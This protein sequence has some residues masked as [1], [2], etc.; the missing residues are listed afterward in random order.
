M[1]FT[2]AGCWILIALWLF[3]LV[4]FAVRRRGGGQK[5]SV[6]AP[7]ARWG[8]VLQGVAFPIVWAPASFQPLPALTRVILSVVLAV[9]AIFIAV[10]ATSSLGKQWRFNAALNPDHHLVQRGPYSIVRH[11]IYVSMLL[12]LLATALIVS[13]W[14]ASCIALVFFLIGTE[15]RVRVEEKLLLSRF[16]S[17]YESYRRRVYAYI[18]GLR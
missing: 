10:S 14:I 3:W 4:P 5:A 15:V 9:F 8:M 6:S 16:G 2:S 13:N 11:P 17:E 1:V 18:P 7:Q 12:M